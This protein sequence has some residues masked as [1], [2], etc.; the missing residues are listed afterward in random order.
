M[1]RSI[2]AD[3]F[4]PVVTVPVFIVGGSQTNAGADIT[5]GFGEASVWVTPL[6]RVTG[7]ATCVYLG[8]VCTLSIELTDSFGSHTTFSVPSKRTLRD[9]DLYDI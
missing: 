8:H 6:S 1:E 9:L 2:S 5:L 3:C 7:V 4:L